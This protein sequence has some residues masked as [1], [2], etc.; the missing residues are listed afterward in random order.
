MSTQASACFSDLPP[1][2]RVQIFRLAA[3]IESDIQP[4]N[5]FDPE[6]KVA[7]GYRI[8]SI[9]ILKFADIDYFYGRHDNL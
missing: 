9:S 2:I 8:I 3:D 5:L 4:D 1:E 6:W 7:T